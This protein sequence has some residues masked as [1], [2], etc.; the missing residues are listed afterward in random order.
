[1]FSELFK[2]LLKRKVPYCVAF[3]IP[4]LIWAGFGAIFGAII[5]LTKAFF[6]NN[7]K[8]NFILALSLSV[9]LAMFFTLVEFGFLGPLSRKFGNKSI[10]TINDNVI[11]GKIKKDISNENL[12]SLYYSLDKAYNLLSRRNWLWT[13]T[14]ATVVSLADYFNSFRLSNFFIILIIGF[15]VA[16]ITAVYNIAIASEEL[17]SP[18]RKECKEI[19][20]S[21]KLLYE[22][23][24]TINFRKRLWLFTLLVILL[25]SLIFFSFQ[26]LT[27]NLIIISFI[28]FTMIVLIGRAL[29]LTFYRDISGIQLFAEGL[30]AGEKSVFYSGRADQGICGIEKS[31]NQIAE[32]INKYQTNLEEAKTVLEIKVKARTSELEELAKGLD[33]KAKQRT[34]ELQERVNELEK[35]QRLAVGRE[36]KMIAL[37]KEI[38][39]L[40]MEL[41]KYRKNI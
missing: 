32:N 41:A 17:L 38:K 11:G 36:L 2:F 24:S 21:R 7:A 8:E 4:G 25:P 22:T 18:L 34:K 39:G 31:L 5:I 23:Q 26:P 6:D 1:M 20:N 12:L 29:F 14:V 19:L 15:S 40:E 16:F 3:V 35:F 33:E 10:K 13:L 37:K 27:L 30:G 28:G 9:L